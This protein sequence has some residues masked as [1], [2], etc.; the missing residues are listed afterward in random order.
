MKT[1]PRVEILTGVKLLDYLGFEPD[2][3]YDI[4]REEI[5]H[6]E[7]EIERLTRRLN[8]S[9]LAPDC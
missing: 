6:L 3:R 8:D 4:I 1:D 7:N 2:D 9:P 5:V